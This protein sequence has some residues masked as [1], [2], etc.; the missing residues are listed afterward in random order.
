MVKNSKSSKL[1]PGAVVLLLLVVA[2]FA[3]SAA[4]KLTSSSQAAESDLNAPSAGNIGRNVP[5]GF[6][7]ARRYSE[8]ITGPDKQTGPDHSVAKLVDK[9]AAIPKAITIRSGLNDKD[10]DSSWGYLHRDVIV[11]GAPAQLF[12]N[13]PEPSGGLWILQWKGADGSWTQL[14]G[15]NLASSEILFEVAGSLN[16]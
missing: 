2:A 14:L 6:S 13:T 9:N 5:A 8:R 3:S 1:G 16:H 10:A 15:R 12:H 4:G 11:H 7:E